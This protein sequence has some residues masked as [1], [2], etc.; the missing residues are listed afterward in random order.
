M[1]PKL[2]QLLSQVYLAN[3]LVKE[4]NTVLNRAY[5]DYMSYR[6]RL[7]TCD[8]KKQAEC[9]EKLLCLIAK[10]EFINW[11][12]LTH[13]QDKFLAE[14]VNALHQYNDSGVNNND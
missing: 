11:D 4:S 10:I 2:K 13:Q 14:C 7:N 3:T 8:S 6:T 12:N 5:T 9:L 1:E